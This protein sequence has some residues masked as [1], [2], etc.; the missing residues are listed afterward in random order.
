MAHFDFLDKKSFFRQNETLLVSVICVLVVVAGVFYFLNGNKNTTTISS[1]SSPSTLSQGQKVLAL[2]SADVLA[3]ERR[4]ATGT[5]VA[6]ITPTQKQTLLT[7]I[8][9]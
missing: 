9:K 8:K 2:T 3:L 5:P 7:R 6:H 4:I 1:V